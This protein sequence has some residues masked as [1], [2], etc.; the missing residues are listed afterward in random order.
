LNLE[1]RFEVCISE[2]RF[3][4]VNIDGSHHIDQTDEIKK[5]AKNIKMSAFDVQTGERIYLQ[6]T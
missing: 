4:H 2:H 6:D 5:I 1:G 3:L